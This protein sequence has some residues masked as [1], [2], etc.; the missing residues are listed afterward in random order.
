MVKS[1]KIHFGE[2]TGFAGRP[3]VRYKAASR[4]IPRFLVQAARR[5]KLA[6]TETGKAA[7]ETGLWTTT[8]SSIR[9]TL[10]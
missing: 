1:E 10:S 9:D 4:M 7:G 6:L 8:G 3:D 2:P 5:M